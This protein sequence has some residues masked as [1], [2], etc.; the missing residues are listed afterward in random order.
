MHSRFWK[1]T[2]FTAHFT[3]AEEGIGKEF[4]C[5]TTRGLRLDE[6]D[7]MSILIKKSTQAS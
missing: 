7:I 2:L 5:N 4:I 1:L 6:H 3:I